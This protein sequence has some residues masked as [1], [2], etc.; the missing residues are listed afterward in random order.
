MMSSN[1][2]EFNNLLRICQIGSE[3][4]ASVDS[5]VTTIS[6]DGNAT[7]NGMTFK[8]MFIE[9]RLRSTKG[10]L[11]LNEEVVAGGMVNENSSSDEFV[12]FSFFTK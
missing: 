3:L 5:I 2:R 1:C 12:F 7:L 11:I 6:K 4:L 10:Y 9:D 8:T